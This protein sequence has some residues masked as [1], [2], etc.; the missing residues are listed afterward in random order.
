[1][2]LRFGERSFRV[3]IY[4]LATRPKH[5]YGAVVKFADRLLSAEGL[6]HDEAIAALIR[7]L[8]PA[9]EAVRDEAGVRIG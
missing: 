4:C 8:D 2:A 9:I 3:R 7:L 5:R 6:T 1:V